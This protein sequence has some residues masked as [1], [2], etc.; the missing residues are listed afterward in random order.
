MIHTMIRSIVAVLILALLPASSQAFPKPSPYAISWE[1]KF[2]YATPKRIVVRTSP[3]REPEAFWY[4]TFTVTNL[5]REEHNF[6]PYF[7]MLA[8][9]GQVF[10]SDN[11]IP[12]T[13]LETIRIKERNPR[14]EA[15]NDIAGQLRVGEDQAREGVAIWPEP[16]PKMGRFSIFISGL[17]GESVILKDAKGNPMERTNPE[18]KKEPIVLWKT[19]QI[20]YFVPGDEKNPGNDV[21]DLVEQQWVMR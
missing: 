12:L 5:S 16:N 10:R 17:S 21:I 1:F 14:L 6:L 4:M 13:V 15:L 18:G 8:N 20:D 2:D 7:E 11:H 19:L 3:A 9:D